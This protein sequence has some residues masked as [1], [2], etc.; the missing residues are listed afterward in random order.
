MAGLA[1]L[2]SRCFDT[3]IIRGIRYPAELCGLGLDASLNHDDGK[4]DEAYWQLQWWGFFEEPRGSWRERLKALSNPFRAVAR[5]VWKVTPAS[6]KAAAA[7][8]MKSTFNRRVS[9]V[10]ANLRE[11]QP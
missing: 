1:F 3:K 8:G 9:Y 7:C 10:K 4:P 5:P 2:K 6:P 11:G